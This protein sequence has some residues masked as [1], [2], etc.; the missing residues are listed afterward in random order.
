MNMPA[1]LQTNCADDARQDPAIAGKPF[2]DMAAVRGGPTVYAGR[3]AV[4]AWFE[5]AIPTASAIAAPRAIRSAANEHHI[6]AEVA[7]DF[8][9]SPALLTFHFVIRDDQIAELEIA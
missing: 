7:G 5:R 2:S 3:T 4:F 6:T 8:P 9:G 1:R